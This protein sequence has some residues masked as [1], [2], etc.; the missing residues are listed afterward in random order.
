MNWYYNLKLNAKLLLGFIGV[1][2]I[3]VIVG[4]IG[5]IG[6]AEIGRN[7]D[8]LYTDRLKPVEDLGFANAALLISRGDV[9]AML[10]TTDLN[11]RK[12]YASSIQKQTKTVDDLV[13]KYSKTYLVK[14]EEE[15]LPLFLSDWD[16]YKKERDEAIELLLKFEDTEAHR[17]IYVESLQHQLDARK[18]LK[19]L[20]DINVKVADELDKAT[21]ASLNSSITLL[22]IFVIA[23]ALLA[24]VMGLFISKIISKPVNN[25]V[26]AANSL[27]LGDISV[28]INAK[29]KDEIG[30]L[31]RAF[32]LM[33][34]NIKEQAAASEKI[35]EGDLNV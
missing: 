3:T 4:Y 8:S 17:L 30:D 20:I 14:E 5:Y 27:A 18:H 1:S 2:A 32:Q 15:T 29:T 10:G 21:D 13:N 12:D 35:S 34:E 11:Q 25:L 22:I 19:E 28:S 31:E 16:E 33:I 26:T 7:Q 24:I 9:V 6:I 23:G